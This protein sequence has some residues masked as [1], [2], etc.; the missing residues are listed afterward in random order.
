LIF[1]LLNSLA[2][3]AHPFHVEDMQK[4]MRIG[5]ADLSPDGKWIAYSVQTS[6]VAK[7]KSATNLWL[8]SSNGGAATQLT[9][10]DKGQN[11]SPRWSPDSKYLFFVSSRDKDIPQI[12]RIAI[13]GGESNQLTQW[14]IGVNAFIL[15]PD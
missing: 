7:N 1:V 6:D 8:I 5:E 12:F 10:S 9:F 14:A 2:W 4:L 11:Y 3:A 13:S 15:S